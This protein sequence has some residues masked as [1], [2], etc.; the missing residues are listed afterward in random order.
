VPVAFCKLLLKK[1]DKLFG[2]RFLHTRDATK[3]TAPTASTHFRSIGEKG[4]ITIILGQKVV[5]F[6]W[7]TVGETSDSFSSRCMDNRN[8]GDFS[9]HGRLKESNCDRVDA[10]PNCVTWL[11]EQLHI[12]GTVRGKQLRGPSQEY[13]MGHFIKYLTLFKCIGWR[14]Y[15]LKHLYVLNHTNN[16]ISSYISSLPNTRISIKCLL[17]D[18]ISDV[19]IVC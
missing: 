13:N 5:E 18:L 12:T 6:D 2:R 4:S 9:S 17:W 11:S 1:L 16:I 19:S 10:R 15:R 8:P 3:A 7:K 14:I